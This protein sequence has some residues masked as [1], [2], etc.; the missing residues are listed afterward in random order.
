MKRNNMNEEL[1]KE[2]E[3]DILAITD[4]I[5]I[6][7]DKP[8]QPVPKQDHNTKK[9]ANKKLGLKDYSSKFNPP[10]YNGL[11]PSLPG[12]SGLSHTLI[13]LQPPLQFT[14]PTHLLSRNQRRRRNKA[15][16]K[17]TPQPP[18]PP[19]PAPI[20]QPAVFPPHYLPGYLENW[21]NTYNPA[22]AHVP[23]PHRRAVR[24][25]FD[26]GGDVERWARER[27]L[28]LSAPPA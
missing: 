11:L 17:S 23:P 12:P 19:P 2:E 27:G 1:S 15:A 24:N 8:I 21:M 4:D 10:S 18:P 26:Y 13:F 14:P 7:D 22:L 6:F 3:D 9:A 5:D 28:G 20:Y 25:N 16:N